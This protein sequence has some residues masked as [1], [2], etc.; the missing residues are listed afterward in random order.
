MIAVGVAKVFFCITSPFFTLPGSQTIS[1][2]ALV[3]F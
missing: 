3:G 1:P 2:T